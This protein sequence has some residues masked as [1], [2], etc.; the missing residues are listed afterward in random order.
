MT[1]YL[2]KILNYRFSLAVR[3]SRVTVKLSLNLWAYL[4]ALNVILTLTSCSP[5]NVIDP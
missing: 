4:T 1:D 3:P 5:L 2:N